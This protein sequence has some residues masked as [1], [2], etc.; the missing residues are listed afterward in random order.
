VELGAAWLDGG[1][2]IALTTW[3]SSS[4][5]PIAESAELTDD[6]LAVTLTDASPQGTEPACTRDNVQRATAVAVPEG[7]DPAQDLP[8]EVTYAS[9][10]GEVT[11]AGI[12]GL[13]AP[14]SPTDYAP[15]A[16]WVDDAGTFAFVTWGSSSC[17]PEIEDVQA[18]TA[19]EVT[20][21][22]ATPPA[23]RVCTMD[24]APQVALA[25]A[26]GLDR[27]AGAELVLQGDTFEAVRVPILG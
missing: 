24:I 12:E 21:T 11:L 25:V 1:R 23:D 6:V 27:A 19:T 10:A 4:C 14:T 13:A 22:F 26:Q 16:G 18:T 7:V 15:S 3:G 9:A 8:I 5:R 17:A 20:V 2:M